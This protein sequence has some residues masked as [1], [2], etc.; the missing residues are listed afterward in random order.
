MIYQE[1]CPDNLKESLRAYV[2]GRPTGD[3]LRACL[4]NDLW[5]ACMRAD[6]EN[7]HRL[8]AIVMFI[9]D[10]VPTFIRGSKEAVQKHLTLKAEERAGI[11]RCPDC[12]AIQGHM[13]GC[14]KL[15]FRA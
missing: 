12:S 15:E 2:T 5:T 1:D 10:E 3:F 7:Q 9:V 4:E 11:K 8:P 13:K 14:P 6:G